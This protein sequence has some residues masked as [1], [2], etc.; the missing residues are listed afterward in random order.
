MTSTKPNR[1]KEWLEILR[2]TSNSVVVFTTGMAGCSIAH[3]LAINGV[4][5]SC[6]ADNSEEKIGK[7]IDLGI[8]VAETLSF[9]DLLAYYSDAYVVI[10]PHRYIKDIKKQFLK[11]GYDEKKLISID[12]NVLVYTHDIEKCENAF[13]LLADSRSRSIFHER[14]DFLN[15]G[16]VKHLGK[17]CDPDT[18]YFDSE[19]LIFADDEIV[20]DG[21]G[22]ASGSTFLK[23][24]NRTKAFKRYL[25]CEPD[26]GNMHMA[27][28]NLSQYGNIEFVPKALWSKCDVLC[29]SATA[30][31]VSH[32][33]TGVADYKNQV[34]VTSI[35]ELLGGQRCTFIKMDVEGAEMEALRGAVETISKYKPKLAICA[36][37]KPGDFIDIPL[38]INETNSD[39]A[40]YLRHYSADRYNT[41]CYAV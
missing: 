12:F 16:D 9:N 31:T 41:V 40:I 35:D 10:P 20:I 11:V 28:T 25:F 13:Y 37:H 5:I 15:T 24:M 3:A 26:P 14:L 33:K 34:E 19:I 39:Y 21:G 6:F 8:V 36:Y 18:M 27:K 7:K 38:L 4:K 30:T 32:L 17:T 23:L 29:F 22:G 1:A 2:K